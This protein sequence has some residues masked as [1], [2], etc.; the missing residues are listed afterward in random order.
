MGEKKPS[1]AMQFAGECVEEW[2]NMGQFETNHSMK[3]YHQLLVL[4]TAGA[5][6]FA[7][8]SSTPTNVDTG[9]IRARTFSFISAGPKPFPTYADDRRAIND[10]IQNSITQTLSSRGVSKV[11]QGGD[12]TVAYLIITGNN[13]SVTSINDY[14]GYRADDAEALQ[15]KAF[16]A[17]TKNNNPNYFEA[18]TLVIDLIDTKTSK[19]L[20]R[21]YASRPLLRNPPADVRATRLQ[22]VVDEI[23]A[24]LQIAP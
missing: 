6:S 16:N 19:L 23:F 20:K 14:F 5:W 1:A 22:E 21:G 4:L 9:P 13:A 7:G 11:A 10:M 8:C 17:Y 18:G 24:K 15:N 2:L 3:P 12:I